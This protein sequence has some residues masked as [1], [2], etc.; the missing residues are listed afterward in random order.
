MWKIRIHDKGEAIQLV[1]AF[2]AE[3]ACNEVKLFM[4][5]VTENQIL[6]G[7]VKHLKSTLKSLE[8]VSELISDFYGWA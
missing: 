8:T 1:K 7:L 3:N 6:E 4:G 5:I 2:T